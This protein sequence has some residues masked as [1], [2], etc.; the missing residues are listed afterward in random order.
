LGAC[1]DGNLLAGAMIFRYGHV[2]HTQYLACSESGRALGALD[3]VISTV[4]EKATEAGAQYLSF[5]TSTEQDGRVLNMGLLWQ[6]ESFGA[7]SIV[8][9]SMS[10][11]LK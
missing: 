4:K 7:R 2:W 10:G 8:C 1:L 9:D 3:L 11:E 5:G 6:K